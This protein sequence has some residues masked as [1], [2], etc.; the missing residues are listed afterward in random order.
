MRKLKI[1]FIVLC[2]S[3][4][5]MTVALCSCADAFVYL[6]RV[7]L[8]KG[9]AHYAMGQVY[10]LLGMTNNA[11]L[12]YEKAAQYDETCYLIHLRLGADYARLNMFNKAEKELEVVDNYNPEDLQSHYLLALI[13]STQKDYNKAAEQYE[14]I[15]NRFSKKEPKNVEVYGYLGQL[16]YSQKKS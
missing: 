3:V 14:I 10:D 4:F 16:Y 11:V 5:A 7:S 1:N 9:L 2:F 8:A 13:Y 12:E 6:D 15:L